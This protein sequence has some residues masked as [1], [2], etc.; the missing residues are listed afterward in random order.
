[1]IFGVL[2]EVSMVL[3]SHLT[4]DSNRKGAIEGGAHIG[5]YL[6]EGGVHFG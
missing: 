3:N 5:Q 1:M 2:A 4:S 6:I